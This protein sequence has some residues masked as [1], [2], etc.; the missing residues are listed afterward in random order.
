VCE[1]R[2]QVRQSGFK[3]GTEKV[4]HVN[5]QVRP[6]IILNVLGHPLIQS[7]SW[8]EDANTNRTTTTVS[9]PTSKSIPTHTTS[10]SNHPVCLLP[11]RRA[12]PIPNGLATSE[13]FESHITP[14]RSTNRRQKGE[15]V[16]KEDTDGDALMND[17]DQLSLLAQ[18]YPG[19]AEDDPIAVVCKDGPQAGGG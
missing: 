8:S 2:L 1:A 10:G 19:C 5:E 15:E 13:S 11:L 18:T 14:S 3:C 12:G 17:N 6:I 4:E 9:L 7:F 16:T